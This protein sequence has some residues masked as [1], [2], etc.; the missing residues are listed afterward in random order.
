ML[1][2]EFK[3]TLPD[4][5]EVAQQMQNIA[6]QGQDQKPFQKGAD[7]IKDKPTDPTLKQKE[8]GMR[9]NKTDRQ[10]PI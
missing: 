1:P 8:P 6:S 3:E 10:I 9:R 5:L 4:P 7:K 2:P